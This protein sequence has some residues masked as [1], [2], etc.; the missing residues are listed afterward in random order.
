VLEHATDAAVI[1]AVVLDN[2][3]IGLVQDGRAEKA[4]DV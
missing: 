4:L 1:L 2:A 3:M